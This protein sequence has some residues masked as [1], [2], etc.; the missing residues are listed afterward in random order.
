[1]RNSSFHFLL[2]VSAAEAEAA[3][4]SSSAATMIT[5]ETALWS[6]ALPPLAKS[7][8]PVLITGFHKSVTW[9]HTTSLGV[10]QHCIYNPKIIYILRSCSLLR[11]RYSPS[12]RDLELKIHRTA[13][14]NISMYIVSKRKTASPIV[15]FS[16][17]QRNR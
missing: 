17:E 10:L 11:L 9:G 13:P 4:V 15:F 6:Q 2:L 1:M 12:K 5:F 8:I 14:P 16:I 7:T 3:N